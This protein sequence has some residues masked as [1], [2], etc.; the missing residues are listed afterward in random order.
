[1]VAT[2]ALLPHLLGDDEVNNNGPVYT[3]WM[4][5]IDACI[6]PA[7]DYATMQAESDTGLLKEPLVIFHAAQYFNPVIMSR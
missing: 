6:M 7:R 5:Y 4:E 1:L 3:A 2:R